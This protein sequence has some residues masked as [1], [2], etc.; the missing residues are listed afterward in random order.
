MPSLRRRGPSAPIALCLAL[1][2]SPALAAAGPPVE[3]PAEPSARCT[4]AP[5]VTCHPHWQL[6]A[7]YRLLGIGLSSLPVDELGTRLGQKAWTEQRLSVLGRYINDGLNL[8]FELGGYLFNGQLSGDVSSVGSVGGR[9]LYPRNHLD[10]FRRYE[11]RRAVLEWQSPIGL[12]RI[13]HTTN[14]WGYGILANSGELELD[15]DD[16]RLGDLVERIAFAT[17]PF[18]ARSNLVTALAFDVVYRDSNSSLVDGDVGLNAIA[19]VF[20]QQRS[21]FVG[22]FGT[23]RHQRDRDGDRIN[24]A[25]LDLHARME[26]TFPA[27]PVR[28]HAGFEVVTLLGQTNRVRP[29]ARPEG[30]DIVSAGGVLRLGVEHSDRK[31]GITVDTGFA[32]GDNDSN[33]GTLRQHTLHPDF[34][35][36]MVLFPEVMGA[37]SARNADRA[38]D[39]ARVG[40]PPAGTENLPT[41]GSVQNAVYVWPRVFFRPIPNLTFRAGLLYA[42]TVAD[43]SAPFNTFR[44]GGISR[45]PFDAAGTSHDLGLEVQA[46]VRYTHELPKG[47]AIHAGLEWGHLF[48]GAAFNDAAGRG[49][50]DIDRVVGRFVLE[51]RGEK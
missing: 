4:P 33:D 24:A 25:A 42:R 22:F 7:E 47:F 39:P 45:T 38:A 31:F 41:N 26:H 8:K 43:F 48:P 18:G 2:L 49:M 27:A 3:A 36:G 34:R 17:K 51:W 44:A 50:V 15:F 40:Q 30:V 13:G 20:W 28:V 29:D 19:S 35:V 10:S 37:L 32:S 11:P 23:Y 16:A 6:R 46:G 21:A 9:L 12:L 5:G 1:S 14:T